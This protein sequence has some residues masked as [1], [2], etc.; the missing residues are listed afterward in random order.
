MRLGEQRARILTVASYA[1]AF[2]PVAVMALS[3]LVLSALS[4]VGLPCWWRTSSW[5]GI[6]ASGEQ[7]SG[8][9]GGWACALP[10]PPDTLTWAIAA[11]GVICLAIAA[12]T[13]RALLRRDHA[14]A[15]PLIG[16]S[17]LVCAVGYVGLAAI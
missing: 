14:R 10:S 9:S 2:V 17:L 6:N 1:V 13:I 12:L 8:S 11:Y 3:P 5:V 4:L 7:E 15:L 16:L